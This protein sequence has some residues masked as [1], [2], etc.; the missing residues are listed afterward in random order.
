MVIF[1]VLVLVLDCRASLV[2]DHLLD[3]HSDHLS[4]W[5][6]SPLQLYRCGIDSPLDAVAAVVCTCC[7]HSSVQTGCNFTSRLAPA[8][9]IA[10]KNGIVGTQL[11]PS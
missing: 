8:C 2:C 9:Y 6:F 1:M 7:D 4:G 3:G 10:T 11:H 5:S